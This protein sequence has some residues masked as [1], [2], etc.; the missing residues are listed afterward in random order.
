MLEQQTPTLE[1]F[2][3]RLADLDTEMQ[4]EIAQL[5][6]LYEVGPKHV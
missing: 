2:R 1:E 5:R 6:R 3:L 4:E